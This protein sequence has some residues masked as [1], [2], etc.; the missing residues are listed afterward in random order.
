MSTMYQNSLEICQK[1]LGEGA[2]QFLDRQIKSHLNKP[3]EEVKPE[4][5][6]ELAKWF[7]ISGTLLIGKEKAQKMSNDLISV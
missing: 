7:K 6:T 5:K 4:D 1:Y 3:L 2:K